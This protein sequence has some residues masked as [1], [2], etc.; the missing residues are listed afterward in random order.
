MPTILR[1]CG[2]RP[3]VNL[4]P[5]L[6]FGLAGTL[7]GIACVGLCYWPLRL[8][9]Y[10]QVI[11]FSAEASLWLLPLP[12]GIFAFI[13]SEGFNSFHL[14]V[15]MGIRRGLLVAGF[16][17][18]AFLV[19]LSIAT[20]RIHFIEVLPGFLFFGGLFFGPF[21]LFFGGLAGYLLRRHSP[22]DSSDSQS[23]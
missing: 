19:A 9:E 13:A 8:A 14:R 17:L 12:C 2:T 23:P 15:P 18:C 10:P 1:T 11:G 21:V 3:E 20:A 4:R 7:A 5:S 16:S 6:S 22:G